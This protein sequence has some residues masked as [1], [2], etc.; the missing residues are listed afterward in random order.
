M[1]SAYTCPYVAKRE[2]YLYDDAYAG[3]PNWDIGRP[4]R[5]FVHLA[6]TGRVQGPVLDVGCG[7][8]ELALFLAR[9][10]HD[11]LGIDLSPRA[12]D[13]ATAK[14]RW[15]R[16]E[17]AHFLVWD[18]LDLPDLAGHGFRFRTVTDCA[19]FHVLAERDRDA[20][21]DGLETVIS[22]GGLY[23]VL[24]DERRHPD[25]TYGISPRELSDRFRATDGWEVEFVYE[26]AFERRYANTPAYLAGIR[27]TT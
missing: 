9:R 20:F 2:A 10:G 5:A 8:G 19:M 12:V 16:V 25:E 1:R 27:R 18:A 24:G 22:S 17:R 6:E 4:Q 15:R 23:C 11:V 13:Q 7:T 21:V 26:T 14:A 3:V